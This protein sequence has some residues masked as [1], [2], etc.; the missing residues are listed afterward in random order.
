LAWLEQQGHWVDP[1]PHVLPDGRKY[2]E[3]DGLPRSEEEIVRHLTEGRP[4]DEP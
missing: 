4:L 1:E 3:V 2:Y